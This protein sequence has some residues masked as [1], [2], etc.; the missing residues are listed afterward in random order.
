MVLCRA[1]LLCCYLPG[2]FLSVP[3]KRAGSSQDNVEDID[4]LWDE[5]GNGNIA[6]RENGTMTVMPAG[7]CGQDAGKKPLVIFKPIALVNK[8]EMLDFALNDEELL[9]KGEEKIRAAGVQV[10][11]GARK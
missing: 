6:V 4:K 5:A 9:A 2:P 7:Y 11:R 8:F 10:T 1:R 3:D